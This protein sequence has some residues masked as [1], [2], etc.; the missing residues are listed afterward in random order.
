MES[1]VRTGGNIV[2]SIYEVE[3]G[4]KGTPT[5]RERT[6]MKVLENQAGDLKKK[7]QRQTRY[8]T[9][10]LKAF[11]FISS[12]STS[13]KKKQGLRCHCLNSRQGGE[14]RDSSP[15]MKRI[16]WTIHTLDQE[17]SSSVHGRLL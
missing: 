13:V 1:R 5:W 4:A 16:F 3:G 14:V 17:P 6:A 10:A 2:S 15:A 8:Q 9:A 11:F 7:I 12:C